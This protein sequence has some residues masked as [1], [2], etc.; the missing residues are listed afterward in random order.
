[1]RK[2]LL[3]LLLLACSNN[4]FALYGYDYIWEIG[5]WIGWGAVVENPEAGCRAGE[6]T[7]SYGQTYIYRGYRLTSPDRAA[8]IFSYITPQGE[9]QG[10]GEWL[11]WGVYRF[12]D[13]CT[14]GSIYDP[15][16]LKC[17]MPDASAGSLCL[18]QS[19]ATAGNP[20]LK[21]I[22]GSCKSLSRSPS[23]KGYEA[24][25]SC[26]ATAGNPINFASGN[27]VQTELDFTVQGNSPLALQR[28]YNSIDG[29]WRHNYSANLSAGTSFALITLPDGKEIYF[30]VSG[31][32]AHA[33]RE[34]VGE[35]R[36]TAGVWEYTAPDNRRMG[37]DS[38]G[39][40]S[41][42]IQP[43][44]ERTTLSYG[45]SA[46][47]LQDDAGNSLALT[48]DE[49]HHPTRLAGDSIEIQYTYDYLSRLTKLTRTLNG[50]VNERTYH[51]DPTPG[52]RLLTGITDE[53]GIRFATWTYDD[54]GRAI[55]S[56][57][58]GGAERTLVNY[59]ADGSSTVTN[60]LGKRTTYRFQTIQGIRRIT[61]I[62]G[63]PSANCPNSNSTFTYDDR[64]LVKTRTDNKGNVTRFDYNER[65][66]EVS[67]TEAYGTP[68]ARTVTTE[69]HPT[70]FLP[71]TITE[72]DRTTRYSYDTQ[73]RLIGQTT[74]Q[75]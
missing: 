49:Q 63:E 31:D 34:G 26:G 68:Q 54:Q 71:V 58:A 42:A 16:K 48:E 40:L 51:Y 52:S 23:Q 66:L 47:T 33:T 18:D 27:K 3:P 70:L 9:N 69:W 37:F 43:S 25:P 35:L 36:K 56:E 45:A 73:G 15:T 38:Q 12:G 8:C 20:L 30:Q 72:P 59:N 24:G 64:G 10:E 21:Q 13:G 65:G 53:R 46:I 7:N 6:H 2:H 44:G 60:A 39:R 19:G 1:M 62:E 41:Y 29:F 22:D 67:R 75:R 50:Q 32:Q 17:T 61:T 55:S 11:N 5:N 28:T 74:T 57:H 14:G 4:A